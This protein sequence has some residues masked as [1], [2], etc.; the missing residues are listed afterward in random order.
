MLPDAA[1]TT[2]KQFDMLTGTPPDGDVIYICAAIN[3]QK[4]CEGNPE[5]HHVN[6]DATIRIM[7]HYVAR[8]AFPV[9]ISSR[10]LEWSDSTYS[11]QK[12]M[13]EC[14]AINLPVGIVRAGRI[15]QE[16]VVELCDVLIKVGK[17]RSPGLRVW[18]TD[19]IAYKQ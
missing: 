12:A 19:D 18:G 10:S 14:V 16:N 5:S 4:R 15:T 1:C 8:G 2:R 9:W 6:V 13:V 17:E 11:R 3:G 7:K